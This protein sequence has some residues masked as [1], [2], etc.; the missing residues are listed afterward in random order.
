MIKT[1]QCF[2][3]TYELVHRQRY[4]LTFLK[5][6]DSD[7]QVHLFNTISD[8]STHFPTYNKSAAD[9]FKNVYSKIWKISI[10]VGLITNKKIENFVSKGEIAR[11]EQFLLLSQYFQKSSAAYASTGGKG[12]TEASKKIM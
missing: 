1:Q 4:K 8:Y 6:V 3:Y 9:D 10:I 7:Y 11:F 12:L 2:I 5:S